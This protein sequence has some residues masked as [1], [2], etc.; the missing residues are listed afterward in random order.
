[1]TI[2]FAVLNVSALSIVVTSDI[3]TNTTWDADTIFIDK[4]DFTIQSGSR[5]TI[6]PG[7]VIRFIKVLR[8]ITVRGTITAI[9]T[10]NDSIRFSHENPAITWQGIRLTGRGHATGTYDTS[11]IKYCSIAN[12]TSTETDSLYMKRGGALYCGAGNYVKLGN[13][14]FSKCKGYHGGAVYI[15]SGAIVR[16]DQ[17][18]F[19]SNTAGFLGGGAIKT[20]DNGSAD[21][22]V[23]NSLFQ[24]NYA[25]PGGAVR[26]G[27]GTKAEFNNCVFYRDTT[28]S[29]NPENGDLNG[30]A[31]TVSGPADVTLRGCII[32]HCRSYGKGG[33]IYSTDA[34]VNLI[35]CTII[36]NASVYG[37]CIY[38]A[39][40]SA[41]SSPKLIN[42]IIDGST[43]PNVKIPCDSAG[44]GVFID[45]SVIPEFRYCLLG[46]TVYD[47]TNKLY[48]HD[49]INSQ[50]S[51]TNF[52]FR[53][54]HDYY[55]TLV[56]GYQLDRKDPGVN[57][58]TPDTTGLGLPEYDLLGQKRIFGS[59]VDIGAIEYNDSL[60]K[61]GT[62]FRKLQ[63]QH[64][65]IQCLNGT[66]YSIDGRLVG[67]FTGE[68][69]L[70]AFRLSAGP[71]I[72]RG[73]YIVRKNLTGG[74]LR[75]ERVL[76]R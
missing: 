60:I 46:D 54:K 22:Q 11:Y 47:H 56:T 26:I 69:T 53:I 57:G 16:I 3:T 49:F 1:M 25:R 6:A 48:A 66:V 27:K 58:G 65:N 13:S 43:L 44:C 4:P 71:G 36:G 18:S 68:F 9:G 61:V 21:L 51:R 39:R 23:W 63:L 31:I 33:G 37:G 12:I 67:Q 75:I 5:L 41:S 70:P 64:L 7:T 17:C 62:I 45:S 76:I 10:V 24:L 30:G 52:V 19:Y 42:T 59:A 55:D 29:I 8:F 14:L 32:F 74:E 34:S 20:C 40:N 73:M 28:Q 50:Y 2:L 72:S 15:D 38:F 35:N